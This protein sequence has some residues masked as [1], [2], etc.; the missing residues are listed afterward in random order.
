ML[1]FAFLAIFFLP[2]SHQL[3]TDNRIIGGRDADIS[4]FPF[5]ARSFYRGRAWCGNVIINEWTLISAAHCYENRNASDFKILVGQTDIRNNLTAIQVR[6]VIFYPFF[7][8]FLEH[9]IVVLKLEEQLPPWSEKIQPAMLP[10]AQY[11]P[12]DGTALDVSG[13]KSL[14]VELSLKLW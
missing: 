12:N 10:P 4:E 14:R 2:S 9:D 13:K 11:H 6:E 3:P 7:V 1:I 5:I 8:S